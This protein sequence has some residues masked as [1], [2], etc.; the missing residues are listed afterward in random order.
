MEN[1]TKVNDDVCTSVIHTHREGRFCGRCKQ[2]Y[3][4]AAYSYH[5]TSCI[6]CKDYGY[7]NWLIYFTVALL[8]LTLFYIFMVVFKVSFTSSYINGFVFSIQCALSPIARRILDAWLTEVYGMNDRKSIVTLEKICTSLYGILNLDFFRDI[9]SYF[10][11]HPQANMLHIISLDFIVAVYPFLLISI[12]YLVVKIYDRSYCVKS[13]WKPFKWCLGRFQR[14][15]DIQS[16]LIQT[17]A[18]FI[19]LSNVK[20]LGVCFDLLAFTRAYDSTGAQ[21][22]KLYFYYDANIEYFG[23]E[24]LPFA[25]L[26]LFMAFI[27]AFLPFLLLALYPCRSFQ[28]LLNFLGWRC[29]T[30]HIFMDAFQG[31]YKIEPYDLRSFSAFY[32]LIRFVILLTMGNMLSLFISAVLCVIMVACF[33]ILAIFQPYKNNI[34]NKLDM[35]SM[36]LISFFSIVLTAIAL[37]KYTDSK[38]VHTAIILLFI[39]LGLIVIHTINLTLYLFR[40]QLRNLASKCFICKRKEESLQAIFLET[41]RGPRSE[42]SYLLQ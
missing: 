26:A 27:F 19:L 30:L 31:S 6:P 34:H 39:S 20:I 3:G 22:S 5:Y 15:W 8:P 35:V 1:A 7:K 10:C 37:A 4:L 17:I 38:W 28:K 25:L 14:Q 24:H 16:S 13:A 21:E 2:G 18:T 9:Y 32:F 33:F 42:H 23:R 11:L 36:F 40:K 12:T 29:Q 41:D